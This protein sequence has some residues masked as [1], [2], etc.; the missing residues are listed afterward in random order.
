MSQGAFR[1]IMQRR[2][3]AIYA[4][5]GQW[6]HIWHFTLVAG[7]LAASGR[8]QAGNEAVL[9]PVP[10]MARQRDEQGA[11]NAIPALHPGGPTKIR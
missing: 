2:D 6:T 10:G 7:H 11:L 5:K 4:Q 9:R 3:H 8:H 1:P